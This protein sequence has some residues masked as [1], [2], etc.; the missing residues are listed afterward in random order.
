MRRELFSALRPGGTLVVS[1]ILE[2]RADEVAKGLEAC[3]LNPCRK[4]SQ[5]GWSAIV[6]LR[7]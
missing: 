2:E 7:M 6:F 3:G 4:T 5:G 1:G